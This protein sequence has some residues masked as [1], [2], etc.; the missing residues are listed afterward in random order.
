MTE[1]AAAGELTARL[2][3]GVADRGIGLAYGETRNLG[4]VDLVPVA[5]V[6]YGFGAAEGSSQFGSGGGGGGVAIPIGAY[7]GGRDGG[8][9]EPNTVALLAVAIPVIS[10]LGWAI[11]LIVRAAR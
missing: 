2:A 5:F 3:D 10:A 9:F 6:T 1:T 7:V 11:S 4:G 8:R